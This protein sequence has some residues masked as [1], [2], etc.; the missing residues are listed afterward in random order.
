[1]RALKWNQ[2]LKRKTVLEQ[3]KWLNF[4]NSTPFRSLRKIRK[5]TLYLLRFKSLSTILKKR[6]LLRRLQRSR[7][8]RWKDWSKKNERILHSFRTRYCQ[9]STPKWLLRLKICI[10]RLQVENMSLFKK[11]SSKKFQINQMINLISCTMGSCIQWS[12]LSFQN[13]VIKL[14][15]STLV[16]MQ[17]FWLLN[18]WSKNDFT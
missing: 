6:T 18:K 16:K 7:I 13:L 12:L 14:V 9:I 17:R 1:M 10:F 11:K 15:G 2:N 5:L 8:R 3:L 4:T